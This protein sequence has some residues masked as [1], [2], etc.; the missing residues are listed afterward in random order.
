MAVSVLLLLIACANVANL[1]LAQG[2]A[3]KREIA[4]RLAMGAG[5]KR[6]VRQ[7]LTEGGFLAITGTIAGLVVARWTSKWIVA[8]LSDFQTRV[9]LATPLNMHV[10][11]FSLAT[12]IV[13]VLLCAAIPAFHSTRLE[14]SQ[15]MKSG[16]AGSRRGAIGKLSRTLV[17]AQV[18]MSV[19]ALIAGG[20]LLHSLVNL[21]TM[22]VGF[23]RDHLIAVDWSL[24]GPPRTPPQMKTFN[25]RLM[26]QIG[27]LP[28]VRSVTRSSFAPV[29]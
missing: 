23:D 29:S 10:L 6:L 13:T 15:D 9:V 20:M 12:S 16:S 2:T 28:D 25:D 26:E 18:T 7:L 21:E 17:V 4:V 27:S 19:T 1:L 14:I 11:F 3:R 24:D 22:D 8:S 5:R